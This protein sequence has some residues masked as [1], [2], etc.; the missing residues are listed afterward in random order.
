MSSSAPC[1]QSARGCSPSAR[2][3]GQL[4]RG[5]AGHATLARGMRRAA[6]I[7]AGLVLVSSAG[8]ATIRGTAKA[9]RIQTAFTAVDRINCGAGADLVAA[10]LSDRASGCEVVAR[11]LSVDPYKNTDSQ[12]ESAVEPDSFSAGSTV[13]SAFQVGRRENGASS[14]I[15]TAVSTDAG[16]T[17]QRSFLPGTTT[18]ATPAGP[19]VGA[20][21]PAVAYDAVHGF[22]LVSTLTIERSFSHVYVTRSTDGR[23]WSS[24]V[25]AAGGPVLDKEWIAC[26]NGATS[27]F[28]GRCYLEYTDDQQNTTVS[29]FSTDGGATWSPPVRAGSILVGAQPVIRP[30]GTLVVVAGDYRGEAALSG[31]I[32]ALRSTDGGA[33][34]ARIVVSDLRAADNDPMRAISLPSLDVD[35]NG[36]IYAVWHD[37]R[38]R[39][40]CTQNDMV[41]ATSA[42]G[43]TWS[44]PVRIPL[45]AVSSGM[46]FFIPGLAADPAR[47]GHLA[48]V[49]AYYHPGSKALGIGVA[50]SRDGR[51]WTVRRLDPQAMPTTWLPSA[52]GG[53]MVGDY[54]SVSYA[55]D[56]IVPVFA[57][58]R[59][60]LNGRLREGIF[61]TSVP[62]LK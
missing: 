46:S 11:R 29:Q 24:P 26:D 52:E 37:C 50:Q 17:W 44:A 54:F 51:T 39:P 40:S 18:N 55:G 48:L 21:D 27:P 53:R 5:G 35:S 8:A 59:A 7:L 57:L 28:R 41:L 2:C 3:T 19:A 33:T 38:F 56:R 58:A 10:D 23:S 31:S 9:D 61:A 36:T 13:V 12:H 32:V 14:N 22:W 30:D 49:Y 47:P 43:T 62:A 4:R 1:A 60:P 16:R 25:D 45:A 20:S 42:D 34:F 6:V 15:G